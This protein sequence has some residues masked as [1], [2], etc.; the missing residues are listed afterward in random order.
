MNRLQ[1]IGKIL[2]LAML[3]LPASAFSN[4]CCSQKSSNV[5]S[6]ADLPECCACCKPVSEKPSCCS[7]KDN[8]CSDDDGCRCV[9]PHDVVGVSNHE[10]R[11]RDFSRCLSGYPLPVPSPIVIC[12]L[13]FYSAANDVGPLPFR[14]Q[15]RQALLSRWLN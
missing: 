3:V 5:Q 12:S 9:V 13:D 11:L 15:Q 8:K 10:F 2:C 6:S 14:H 7:S 4:C 1:F